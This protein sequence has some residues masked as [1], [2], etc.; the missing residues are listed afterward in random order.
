M[1]YYYCELLLLELVVKGFFGFYIDCFGRGR[2]FLVKKNVQYDD[3]IIL[4][5]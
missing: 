1:H 5:C 2:G 4:S 3:G